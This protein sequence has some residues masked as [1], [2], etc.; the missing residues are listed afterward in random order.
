QKACSPSSFSSS[1]VQLQDT[2]DIM[3]LPVSAGVCASNDTSCQQYFYNAY[4][5]KTDTL[6]AAF[7]CDY[8]GYGDCTQV[9]SSDTVSAISSA[10]ELIS[11]SLQ[12]PL[13]PL[14]DV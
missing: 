9:D 4:V 2:T 12:F 3:A 5:G 7:Y 13:V 11:S 6:T 10:C 8:L 1:G 14:Q